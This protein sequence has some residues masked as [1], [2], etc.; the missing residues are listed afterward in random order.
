MARG[1]CGCRSLPD[2]MS[3]LVEV[4]LQAGLTFMFQVEEGPLNH[5]P[6]PP[7]SQPRA[8]FRDAVSRSAA[9]KLEVQQ[10]AVS[11]AMKNFNEEPCS[12][13]TTPS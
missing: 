4:D 10:Q 1:L 7:D 6:C 8:R 13:P 2:L 12:F 3:Q 11:A 5:H 9:S